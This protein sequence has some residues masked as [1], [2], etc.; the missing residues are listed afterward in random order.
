M[1]CAS[2]SSAMSSFEIEGRSP[3]Q[4]AVLVVGILFGMLVFMVLVYCE[5]KLE[6]DHER[7]DY[8]PRLRR[9]LNEN[10]EKLYKLE[11]ERAMEI[12]SRKVDSIHNLVGTLQNARGLNQ[13]LQASGTTD[14]EEAVADMLD[15]RVSKHLDSE[16]LLQVHDTPGGDTLNVRGLQ[17][18]VLSVFLGLFGCGITFAF[19]PVFKL[20]CAN[21]EATRYIHGFVEGFS[22]G[23]YCGKVATFVPK[24]QG[25]GFR[26]DMRSRVV[27][28]Q[29][30]VGLFTLGIITMMLASLIPRLNIT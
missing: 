28:T 7:P 3:G 1:I 9:V 5:T 13:S 25:F 8:L 29:L 27:N 21:P 17:F 26:S 6:V 20:F 2:F 18:F 12:Q 16:T 14:I 22:S 15:D 23:M 4:I 11:S 19:V 10:R 30:S 24:L